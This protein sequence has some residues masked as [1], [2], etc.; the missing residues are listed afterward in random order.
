[1]ENMEQWSRRGLILTLLCVP[2]LLYGAMQMRVGES[3]VHE[4][5]PSGL[6][7]KE[8]YESFQAKFGSDHFLIVSWPE[9]RLDDK[10][11]G[12]LTE[13][14]RRDPNGYV[15]GVQ[16]SPEVLER[17]MR[18]PIGLTEGTAKGRLRGVLLGE[19][20]T[21]GVV[22]EISHAGV[23]HQRETMEWILGEADGVEGLGRES[24][25]MAGTMY[26]AY[27]ID[28]AAAR[29]LRRLVIP[30]SIMGVVLAWFCLRSIRGAL[31]VLILA[32][33]GQLSAIAM[34]SL[35]GGVFSAVL[36]VLP[37]LIF[38]LTLSNAVHLMN[39]YRDV[40]VWHSDHWGCRALRLGWKPTLFASLTTSLGMA[41]LGLSQL[42]PVH[43]FGVYSA[44]ALTVATLMLLVIFPA[45]ADGLGAK[46]QRDVERDGEVVGGG[47]QVDDAPGVSASWAKR[48][49]GWMERRALPVSLVGVSILLVSF[50]GLGWLQSSNRFVEMFPAE[51]PTVRDL[52]FLEANLGPV[53]SI[54]VLLEFPKGSGVDVFDQ[55]LVVD[56]VT[57][58][59]RSS[60]MEGG[61]MSA[62][63]YLPLLPKTGSLRDVAKRSVMREALPEHMSSLAEGGWMHDGEEERVWRVMA[64]VSAIGDDDAGELRERVRMVVEESLAGMDDGARP[65]LGFTGLAPVVL[66]TQQMMVKDLG[67]SFTAAFFMI[68]PVMM[69]IARSVWAGVLIMIPNVLPETLVFGSMAWMGYRLDIAGLL[70]ASVA[71]GIAVND[72][73][74]FVHWYSKRLMAGDGRSAAIA[75]TMTHCSKAMV[76]TMLISCCSMVPFLFA[77]FIPTQRFACLMIAMIG[78]S[79]LGDL[80]LLPALLMGPL[81]RWYVVRRVSVGERQ[82]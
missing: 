11:L 64:K 31:T 69:L 4:W 32:G 66:A 80:V 16:S 17:L 25:R 9:C 7:E 23:A 5:L 33:L 45:V 35:T 52:R 10:R 51:S 2:F 50:W 3:D 6:K 48:Y 65:R 12:R 76:H 59:L 36:I 27:A 24:L 42:E 46:F 29:S 82:S 8:Q 54:E 1:M 68:T 40:L 74:H 77:D 67:M 53:S 44:G 63:T 13:A 75:H 30:S 21:A 26:E 43:A 47:L 18:S 58:G 70:T 61:V 22:V 55:L 37:T 14:L 60:D 41:S 79:I 78:S 72:T 81:G 62:V 34:V 19:N 15:K 20:G 57:A 56:R 38:M 71:M 28:Q 49:A 73:L 39:Y